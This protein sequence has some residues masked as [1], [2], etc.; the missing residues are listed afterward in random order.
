[1]PKTATEISRPPATGRKVELAMYFRARCDTACVIF[2]KTIP[3]RPKK[4]PGD[5]GVDDAADGSSIG[6]LGH[7]VDGVLNPP[8]S[9]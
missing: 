3:T 2:A 1:M 4:N 5:H 8:R 7:A 6:T 9:R